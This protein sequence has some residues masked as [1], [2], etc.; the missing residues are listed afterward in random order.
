MNFICFT[1]HAE[2]KFL[3]LGDLVL[4]NTA[5]TNLFSKLDRTYF[6]PVYTDVFAKSPGMESC[7]QE[8]HCSFPEPP[9]S[10]Q[11][12]QGR[13]IWPAKIQM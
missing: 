3:T 6:K 8:R 13:N 9:Q 11:R 4:F 5:S 10:S 12:C 7:A 2:S 1:A